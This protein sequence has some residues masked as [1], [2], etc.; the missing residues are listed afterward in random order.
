MTAKRMNA[1]AKPSK[2]LHL[3][4]YAFGKRE[5]NRQRKAM[6]AAGISVIRQTAD[7]VLWTVRGSG[8]AV[9]I[10]AFLAAEAQRA[11]NRK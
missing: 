5:S 8:G 3:S 11:G 4:E 7:G 2:S 1:P 9:E 10:A 6:E